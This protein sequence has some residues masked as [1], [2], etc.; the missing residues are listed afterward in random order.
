MI[1][2]TGYLII[3]V[4]THFVPAEELLAHFLVHG[5]GGFGSVTA[6]PAQPGVESGCR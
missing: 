1:S 3:Y 4:R 6:L 5:S 2:D